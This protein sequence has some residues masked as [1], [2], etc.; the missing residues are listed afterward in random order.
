MLLINMCLIFFCTHIKI[1]FLRFLA[2]G[3]FIITV[4]S[5]YYYLYFYSFSEL[6]SHCAFLNKIILTEV[7]GPFLEFILILIRNVTL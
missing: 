6:K 3:N 1:S 4:S 7:Y 2:Q 5:I